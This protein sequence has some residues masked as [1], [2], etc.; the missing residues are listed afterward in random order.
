VGGKTGIDL[1][2]GKNLAGAFW[3]PEL[4]ICDTELLD[5]LPTVQMSDGWAEIIKYA[6][7]RDRKLFNI[8]SEEAEP[9]LDS[10]IARCVGI[11]RDIVAL[12]EKEGGLRM[13][14]NFGHTVG[15]A[16]EKCSS[17]TVSHG[18]AVA[19]GMAVITRAAVK[20]GLCDKACLE[21]LLR[22]TEKFKLPDRTGLEEEELFK[23]LL[24][25]KK[26]GSSGLTLIIPAEI[27]SCELKKF[28]LHEVREMLRLGL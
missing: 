10:L 12:D 6:M 21:G 24:S 18:Q 23:A 3:Q 25:D 11:K 5:T 14:L 16:I 26:R 9:D 20:L 8:L 1:K 4:V 27:G 15:H 2:A 22:L 7:I 17:Y 13:L 28:G 19:I